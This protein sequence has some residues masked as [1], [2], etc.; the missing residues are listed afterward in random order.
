MTWII[1]YTE[2]AKQQLRKMDKQ[3]ARK[4]MDY[5]DTRIAILSNARNLGKALSGPLGTYWRYR[6]GDYRIICDIQ[7][8]TVCILVVRLGNRNEIYRRR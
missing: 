8:A 1:S 2:T 3:V 6:I 7:D 5:M 4:I